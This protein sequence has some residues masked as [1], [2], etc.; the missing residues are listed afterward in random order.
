MRRCP[1]RCCAYVVIGHAAAPPISVMNSRRLI[2]APEAMTGHRTNAHLNSGRGQ[3]AS[4]VRFGSKADISLSPDDV[5]FTPNSG[6]WLSVSRCPLCAKSGHWRVNRHHAHR[7]FKSERLRCLEADDEFILSRKLDRQ[8][9]GSCS[10]ENAIDVIGCAAKLVGK[11]E[12]VAH[13]P[14]SM[15]ELGVGID[16]RQAIFRCGLDYDLGIARQKT[17]ARNDEAAV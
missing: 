15:H 5:R 4:D 6:H 11:I 2:A 13:E 14:T 17:V 9:A 7:H 3:E 16:S 8:I 12:G 10:L 1:S